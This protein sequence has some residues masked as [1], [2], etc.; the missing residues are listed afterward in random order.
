MAGTPTPHAI[1]R[2]MAATAHK[3]D[4]EYAQE[5][6][7]L[8]RKVFVSHIE[9]GKWL[10]QT[11]KEMGKDR[12]ANFRATYKLPNLYHY[13]QVAE[14]YETNPRFKQVVPQTKS[15]R[16]TLIMASF[17]DLEWT[18]AAD[19]GLLEK[20]AITIKNV[21]NIKDACKKRFAFVRTTT[22]RTA[23][24][25]QTRKEENDPP[26]TPPPPE[27]EMPDQAQRNDLIV[28]IALIRYKLEQA[29]NIDC[30][31][32]LEDRLRA[33]IAEFYF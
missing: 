5:Y 7:G 8:T 9:L 19:A 27:D 20:T 12:W 10:I 2:R 30:L 4:E 21:T 22:N 28:R 1:G 18:K 14:E 31:R 15:L 24:A 33:L 3:T 23:K 17:D 16:A 11:R 29:D 25:Q 32:A 26:L 6:L 13:V